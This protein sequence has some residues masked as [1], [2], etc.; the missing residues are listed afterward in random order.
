MNRETFREQ[1]NDETGLDWLNSQDEP[2][3]DYVLW[4][5]NK[6]SAAPSYSE[7]QMIGVRRL[8]FEAGR[9]RQAPNLGSEETIPVYQTFTEYLNSLK[10]E[11]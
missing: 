4:L 1:F 10:G 9:M 3:I 2:D 5:E 7:E 11:L 6:L 8:A